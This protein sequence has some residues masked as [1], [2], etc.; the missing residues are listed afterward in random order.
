MTEVEKIKH[1]ASWLKSRVS[2][3]VRAMMSLAWP[4]MVSRIGIISLGFVDTVLVGRYSTQELAYLNLGS[5]T[6]IIL[7]LVMSMG[8]LIGTL[9]YVADA[10]GRKNYKECGQ[11][12]KRSLPYAGSVGLLVILVFI[13]SKFILSLL[14]QGPDL[15]HEGGRIMFILAFGIVGHLFYISCAFFLEAIGRA[16]IAI[17][18]MIIANI[19]NLFMSYSLINGLWIFPELGAEGSALATTILRLLMGFGLWG[20]LYFSPSFKKFGL[21]E[22]VKTHWKDWK[23]QRHLGYASSLSLGAELAAFSALSI[24]A[25]LIGALELAIFGVVL[26]IMSVPFMLAS[27]MGVAAS[28]RVA[29]S[30]SRNDRDDATTAGWTAVGLSSIMV[31][32]GGIFLY[33]LPEQIVSFYSDDPYLIS[34]AAASVAFAAFVLILDGGQ[35]VLA[36]ALRGLGEKWGPMYIQSFSYIVVMIPLSYWLSN[37]MGHGVMGLVEA[38]LYASIVS[39]VLQGYWFHKKVALIIEK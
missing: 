18:V 11:V 21:R 29:V 28:V 26:N 12:L 2:R 1:D 3:H 39:C 37:P 9:V 10:Y 20:Y 25:G 36:S 4:A 17:Y 35:T 14:G 23:D 30:K 24:F 6:L 5:S 32:L 16:K 38:I 15:A 22:P 19:F 31:G 27:G 33:Y 8:L 13:P 7:V 34:G